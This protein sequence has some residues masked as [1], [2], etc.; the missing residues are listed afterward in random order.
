MPFEELVSIIFR[1]GV[2]LVE[3]G[4]R[5]AEDVVDLE[6]LPGG[7]EQQKGR[8]EMHCLLLLRRVGSSESQ[9]AGS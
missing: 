7:C 6:R 3:E 5:A 9:A 4:R 2:L 8:G 1:E